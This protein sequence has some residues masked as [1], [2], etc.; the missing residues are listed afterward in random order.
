MLLL[1]TYTM[2]PPDQ[3][4][5]L[6]VV[7]NCILYPLLEEFF[8]RGGV[9]F[10]LD[11]HDVFSRKIYSNIVVSA[12]FFDLSSLVLGCFSRRIGIFSIADIRLDLSKITKLAALRCYTH[13]FQFNLYVFNLTKKYTPSNHYHDN[14]LIIHSTSLR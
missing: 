6:N 2:S 10:Y 11:Q 1:I 14:Q 9:L 8:F 4:A 12:F 3:G 7:F 5:I 13:V